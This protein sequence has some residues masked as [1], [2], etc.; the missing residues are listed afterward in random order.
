VEAAETQ[1]KEEQ[2]AVV[3]VVVVT[4]TLLH[5]LNSKLQLNQECRC[6]APHQLHLVDRLW[7]HPICLNLSPFLQRQREQSVKFCSKFLKQ[8]LM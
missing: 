4:I 7:T 8:F 6:I 3:V 2:E 5:L 1:E